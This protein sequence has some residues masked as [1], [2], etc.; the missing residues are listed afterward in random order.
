MADVLNR[1]QVAIDSIFGL[2]SAR[3]P[4]R[5]SIVGYLITR[6]TDLDPMAFIPGNGRD[7]RAYAERFANILTV[8]AKESPDPWMDHAIVDIAAEQIGDRAIWDFMFEHSPSLAALEFRPIN[9][10]AINATRRCAYWEA[11]PARILVFTLMPR[12][13]MSVGW[14]LDIA[15]LGMERFGDRFRTALLGT[16]CGAAP[17]SAVVLVASA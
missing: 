2:W 16:H 1:R 5:K 11:E 12:R 17:T 10:I 9:R 15:D 7:R 14:K 6:P 13:R 8:L 3:V 4:G